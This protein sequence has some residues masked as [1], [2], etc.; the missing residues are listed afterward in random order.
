MALNMSNKKYI[1]FDMDGTLIDSIG[2]WNYIDK[3]T[4]RIYSGINVAEDIIQRK[5]ENFLEAN[6][7]SDIYREYFRYL[8][9]K[10]NL[11]ITVEELIEKRLEISEAFFENELDFKTRCR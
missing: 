11:N 4:I 3:T 1:I 6:Q 9:R 7:S 10:Y 8:I 2:I 5:R